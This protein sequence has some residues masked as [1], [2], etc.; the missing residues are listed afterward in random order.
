MD[1]MEINRGEMCVTTFKDRPPPLT[2]NNA[3]N[4]LLL[5]F[6]LSYAQGLAQRS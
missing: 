1:G 3:L 4:D 2:V 5:K 6:I